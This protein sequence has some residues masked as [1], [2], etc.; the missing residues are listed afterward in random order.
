[1]RKMIVCTV[2]CCAATVAAEA[3]LAVYEFTGSSTGDNQFNAVTAPPEN[4]TFGSFL[5]NGV[6]WNTGLNVFNSRGWHSDDTIDPNQY[7]GFQITPGTSFGLYLYSIVFDSRRSGT[8]PTNALVSLFVNGSTLPFGSYS[9][10]PTTTVTTFTFDFA[11]VTQAASA[12]FRF[13]G[14]GTSSSL[15]TLQFDNVQTF[16]AFGAVPEPLATRSVTIIGLL[17]FATWRRLF[18]NKRKVS[19]LSCRRLRPE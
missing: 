2:A 10:A 3:S 1:M 6:T 5:R 8:G 12:E 7:V 13:Y 4:G 19:I 15:G 18:R 11:E 14:F 9:F 16:G 17:G